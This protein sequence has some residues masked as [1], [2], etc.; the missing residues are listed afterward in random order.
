MTGVTT[1]LY[2]RAFSSGVLGD[3]PLWSP[4]IYL[5]KRVAWPGLFSTWARD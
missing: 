1:R 3:S 2:G 4:A 5:A